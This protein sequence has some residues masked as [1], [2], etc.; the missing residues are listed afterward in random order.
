MKKLLLICILLIS[1]GC[2]G[3]YTD[4]RY[5]IRDVEEGYKFGNNNTVDLTKPIEKNNKKIGKIYLDIEISTY[6]TLN[7][8]ENILVIR[9]GKAPNY[10]YEKID[11]E[12]KEKYN[13]IELLEGVTIIKKDGE[14]IKIGEDKIRYT[15]KENPAASIKRAMIYIPETLSGPIVIELGKI[16]IDGKEYKTPKIYMQKY[17]KTESLSLMRDILNEGGEQ[18]GPLYHSEKWVDD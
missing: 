16:K 18:F 15:Y 4:V 2:A 3:L 1:T 13:Y 12:E 7:N 8:G 17:K 14:K 10:P 9:S 5:R 11:F 6:E